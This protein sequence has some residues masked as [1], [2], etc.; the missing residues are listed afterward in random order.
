MHGSPRATPSRARLSNRADVTAR[1]LRPAPYFVERLVALE[2]RLQEAILASRRS[3]EEESAVVRQSGNAVDY[4]GDTI[5]HVDERGEA[6]LLEFCQDWSR[7]HDRPFILIAEGLPGDGRQ[8]F[9]AG[10]DPRD[11]SFECIVDP[12]DGTRGLMY[13]KRSAWA[14]AAVAPGEAVLGRRP[15]LEDV[16]VA[17]QTELPTSR[18]ALVDTLWATAGGGVDGTTRDLGTGAERTFRPAPSRARD[19]S[20]GFATVAKFFPGTKQRAAWLE[21]QLFAQVAGDHPGGAPLVFDDE[22]ISSGGQLYELISGHDRFVADLRP[23]LMDA[24]GLP[25]DRTAPSAG[26]RRL[27]ARPYDLC[28]ELIAREAGVIVTDTWGRR[29]SAPLDTVSDVAWVAYAN[30]HIRSLVE[31]VLQR[32]LRNLGVPEE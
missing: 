5:Y 25:G 27:C 24:A 32:L 6:A 31:P 15:A 12:I 21:E 8:V 23:G 29:L 9:P 22:Y 19:L 4:T 18:A 26:A 16:L 20:H 2:R 1:E 3:P 28:T 7:A 13:D 30:E 10:A 14:L 11:A 17:V